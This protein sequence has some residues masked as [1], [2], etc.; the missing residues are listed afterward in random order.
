[1]LDL[2]D[3]NLTPPTILFLL[4]CYGGTIT[5]SC[6]FSFMQFAR[7]AESYGIEYIIATHTHT[8]LISL[9]RSMMLSQAVEE[10]KEWTHVMWVDADIEWQPE[11]LLMLLAEDKD[12]IGG[13][14]PCKSF[15]LSASSSNKPIENGEETE[16]LIETYY[17]ATGFMLVK[18]HVCETMME[19]YYDE[20]KF[21]YVT[22][23]KRDYKFVD[24][25]APIIDSANDDLYLSEDYAFCKRAVD[26]GFKAFMS[27]RFNLG[28]S[29]GS[30]LFSK[31][32]EKK[33]LKRYQ[34]KGMIKIL[35]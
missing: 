33:M 14:Y 7:V 11:H 1:M 18:R 30:I 28:H 25:F 13:P 26:I 3:S 17:I 10:N 35:D 34:A 8:S 9:G 31:E 27:K 2:E 24:L 21:R 12:I 20:L 22:R 32:E 19:H 15:P 5:E 23:N 29:M 4:P 6:F 16:N